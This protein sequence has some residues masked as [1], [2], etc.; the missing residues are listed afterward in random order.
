MTETAHDRG[1][2]RA[3]DRAAIVTTLARLA[4]ATDERDWATVAATFTPDATGYG[5]EGVPAIVQR[6][7]AHLEGCGPTQHLL[8][9]HRVDVAGD[10]ARSLTY[11]RVYHQGAGT[12]AGSFFECMGEYDDRW[13]RAPGGWRLTSRVFAIRIRLGDP[14]V[15]RPT[16]QQTGTTS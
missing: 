10:V 5:A 6:M 3:A 16:H 1:E 12:T 13:T 7:R 8:G 9:N 11:A 2:D 15:I 14:D 4:Q